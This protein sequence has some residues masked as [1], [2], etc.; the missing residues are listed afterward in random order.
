MGII[1]CINVE[2]GQRRTVVKEERDIRRQPARALVAILEWLQI[3]EVDPEEEGARLISKGDEEINLC[4]PCSISL[5]EAVRF[6]H[7]P[8]GRAEVRKRQRHAEKRR[9]KNA[10]N[11]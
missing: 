9:R 2:E 3:G 5:E 7:S 11:R 4:P 8:A 6:V 10:G 1:T